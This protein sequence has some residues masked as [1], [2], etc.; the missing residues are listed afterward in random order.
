[1]Y[2]NTASDH[3]GE[4]TET[5]SANRLASVFSAANVRQN[6]TILNNRNETVG[7]IDVLVTYADRAII[8]QAKSK[9]LTEAARKGNE[10]ALKND[11]EKAIGDAYTQGFECGKL[12]IDKNYKLV[13][14]NGNKISSHRDF[15][16]IFIICVIAEHFPGLPLLLDQFVKPIEHWIIRAPYAIDLFLLDV[17]CEMLENPL[18]FFSFLNRRHKY[19]KKIHAT[20]EIAILGFHLGHNL[21]FDDGLDSVNLGDDFSANIDAAMYARRDNIPAQRV[22]NGI[23]KKYRNT[24]F[25]NI[26]HEIAK[27]EMSG[28][29]DFGYVLLEASENTANNFSDAAM[30]I[31]SQT[32]ITR[33]VHDFTIMFR[34]G[35]VT[36]H[37]GFCGDDEALERLRAHCEMAKYRA[38]AEQWYG[39]LLSPYEAGKVILAIGCKSEWVEDPAIDMA[40]KKFLTKQ[41]AKSIRAALAS[42]SKRRKTGVNQPCPCGS[43]KKFKKCCRG[44][45]NFQ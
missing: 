24:I 10:D 9:R 30:H 38:K 42:E 21:W 18:Y 12:L 40:I 5:F 19:S 13:D 16:E 15:I 43:G 26:L 41:P 11:I 1:L 2:K 4:F 7:E 45:S 6:V 28:A 20:T 25:G 37:C 8:L 32:Q 44:K 23:L 35:G 17:L 3:R 29:L 14:G 33:R 27:L 36:V 22:P 31:F 39:L 34:E